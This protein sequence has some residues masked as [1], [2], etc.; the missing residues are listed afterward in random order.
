MLGTILKTLCMLCISGQFLN[1]STRK[2]CKGSEFRCCCGKYECVLFCFGFKLLGGGRLI[3]Y[4]KETGG[5][6]KK[7]KAAPRRFVCFSPSSPPI[8][9][10]RYRLLHTAPLGHCPVTDF[11]TFW[12]F[13]VSPDMLVMLNIRRL[14]HLKCQWNCRK[15][16]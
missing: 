15:G 6:L 11:S 16:S 5:E 12:A 2:V 10:P 7:K 3:C 4:I 9:Q 13:P 8:P 1:K 14:S